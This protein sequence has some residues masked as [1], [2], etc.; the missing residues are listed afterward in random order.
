M[1]ILIYNKNNFSF[2]KTTKTFIAEASELNICVPS[3]EILLKIDHT[4]ITF[5]ICKVDRD[6]TNEDIL[7]WRYISNDKNNFNLLIIND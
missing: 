3:D 7:G 6:D 5:N 1:D 2:N 4:G